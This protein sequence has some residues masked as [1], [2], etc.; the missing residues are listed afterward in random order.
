[1]EIGN[2]I[3]SLRKENNITQEELASKLGV[4]R[5]T[6]S[7]W[8]L[9]ETAPDIKQAK[10]LARLFNVS[11][12]KLVGNNIKEE[13]NKQKVYQLGIKAL[14]ITGLIFAGFLVIDIISLI[15]VIILKVG[16]NESKVEEIEMNCSINNNAYVIN[17]GSDGYF[18]CSNCSKELKDKYIDF[19]NIN[20][21]RE[22]INLYFENNNGICE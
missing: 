5:Q 19:S 20:K 16:I 1:M 10:A 12:D 15:I 18:N 13:N 14:K 17:I 9:G 2:K 22:D 8:E 11:L 6:I 21:T 3:L 7:K 4:A